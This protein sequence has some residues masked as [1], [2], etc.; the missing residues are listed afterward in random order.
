MSKTTPPKARQAKKKSSVSNGETMKEASLHPIESEHEGKIQRL[1]SQFELAT[2]AAALDRPENT[3]KATAERALDVWKACGKALEIETLREEFASI[4]KERLAQLGFGQRAL[5]DKTEIKPNGTFIFKLEEEP[6]PLL[7]FL[8]PHFSKNSKSAHMLKKFRDFLRKETEDLEDDE[9][10]SFRKVARSMK[11]YREYGVVSFEAAEL[12]LSFGN[13]LKHEKAEI[14]I[15]RARKGGIAR[16][17]KAEKSPQRK[18]T[19]GSKK[20]GPKQ[21]KAER[22]Q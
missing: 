12:S 20:P 18:K 11:K 8:K 6:M 15:E 1:P 10:T 2:L 9:E 22:K 4:K 19:L 17:E 21:K 5:L 13:F 7:D 16:R 14:K 3:L